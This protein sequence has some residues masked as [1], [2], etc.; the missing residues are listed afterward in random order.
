MVNED[1]RLVRSQ[2]IPG[3]VKKAEKVLRQVRWLLKRNVSYDRVLA[4]TRLANDKRAYFLG[5]FLTNLYKQLSQVPGEVY[6]ERK[7]YLRRM[8]PGSR[9][10]AKLIRRPR[11][12][13]VASFAR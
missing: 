8:R 7:S 6:V 13:F 5:M 10:M 2:V 11:I 12:R 3:S 9:G 4:M 1:V